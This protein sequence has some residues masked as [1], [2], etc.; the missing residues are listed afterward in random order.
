MFTLLALLVYCTMFCEMKFCRN[1]FLCNSVYDA[2]FILCAWTVTEESE[3]PATM[4]K[5]T[6]LYGC[7]V[8]ET[9]SS[10][11]YSLICWTNMGRN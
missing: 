6:L 7:V 4:L 2:M 10:R 8:Y 3:A 1:N 11:A 9:Q 5:V